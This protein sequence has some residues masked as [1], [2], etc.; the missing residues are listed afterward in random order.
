MP[1]NNICNLLH[2]NS[3]NGIHCNF[4]TLVLIGISN[5]LYTKRCI[6]C[7]KPV[8]DENE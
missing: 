8:I 6:Q 3:L 2:L 4:V 7:K 5:D 1:S